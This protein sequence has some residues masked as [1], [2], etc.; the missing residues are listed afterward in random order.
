MRV[1][2][3]FQTNCTINVQSFEMPFFVSERR[4]KT[5]KARNK[6]NA[7]DSFML[8]YKQAAARYNL[9]LN[10]TM[11]ISKECGAVRH[12]GKSARVIVSILDNYLLS[13]T[14]D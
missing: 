14:E 4:N 9:G 5:L 2:T 3:A 7:D 8:T 13:L 12:L 1:V 6:T 11:K 10:T